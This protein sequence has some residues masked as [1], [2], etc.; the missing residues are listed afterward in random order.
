MVAGSGSCLLAH[1]SWGCFNVRLDERH[2]TQ[3]ATV[4]F[5][6]FAVE[7]LNPYRQVEDQ[8]ILRR[9]IGDGSRGIESAVS[10]NQIE[11][12]EKHSRL[13]NIK[14]CGHVVPPK[15]R[16]EVPPAVGPSGDGVIVLVLQRRGRKE[17]WPERSDYITFILISEYRDNHDDNSLSI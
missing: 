11:A 4:V 8:F 5:Q 10:I 12:R 2:S 1:V 16:I 13:Y 17:A 14:Q 7:L 15:L 9:R 6:T 3:R